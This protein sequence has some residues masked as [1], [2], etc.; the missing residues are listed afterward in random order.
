MGQTPCELTPERSAAHRF[1]ASLR[2]AREAQGL[3]QASLGALVFFSGATVGRVEKAERGASRALAERCDAVLGQHG[4][5]LALWEAIDTT[6]VPPLGLPASANAVNDAATVGGCHGRRLRGVASHGT[7]RSGYV[8]PGRCRVL[9]PTRGGMA[10]EGIARSTISKYT[11]SISSQTSREGRVVPQTQ[12][13]ALLSRAC[14]QTLLILW[15]SCRHASQCRRARCVDQT[16]DGE[17]APGNESR[18]CAC[19]VRA[20]PSWFLNT[21]SGTEGGG[22]ESAVRCA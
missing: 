12:R 22:H 7:C 1:G 11:L 6:P 2:A 19:R 18:R 3:S 5:L 13:T 17:P 16:V 4:R 15:R 9:R 8:E 21:A 14:L 20:G 10:P